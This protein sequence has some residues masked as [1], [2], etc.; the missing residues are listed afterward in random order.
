[1]RRVSSPSSRPGTGRSPG[2]VSDHCGRPTADRA[3]SHHHR[4]SVVRGH[5]P[6][7]RCDAP[8]FHTGSANIGRRG[9]W[10]R[11]HGLWWG[12]GG[13][14]A[15]TVQPMC[16]EPYR[17]KDVQTEVQDG[18]LDGVRPVIRPEESTLQAMMSVVVVSGPSDD[19]RSH[20]WWATGVVCCVRW[21]E[22]GR[23]TG[24]TGRVSEHRHP[25]RMRPCIFQKRSAW[26]SSCG[27]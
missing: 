20:C 24:M 3:P 10:V 6:P 27:A 22:G 2:S 15:R 7:T 5:D 21:M 13:G 4:R 18:C 25:R 1:M 16:V 26:S 17:T 8:P 19:D 23:V 12:E 11:D 14:C 9:R